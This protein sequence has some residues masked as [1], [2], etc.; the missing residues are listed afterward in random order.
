[1]VLRTSYT[2]VVLGLALGVPL[3]LAMSRAISAMLY[4]VKWNNPAIIAGAGFVLGGF[5]IAAVI[6]PARRAAAVD[7]V[8]TVRGE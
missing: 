3:A 7:P 4:G 8:E 1:M 2:L 6:A 5:A